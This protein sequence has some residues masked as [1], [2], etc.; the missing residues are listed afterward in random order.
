MIAV[1]TSAARS[2]RFDVRQFR[3]MMAAGV[4]QDQKVELVAGRIYVM[5]DLPPHTFAIGRLIRGLLVMFA[6]DQWTVRQEQPVLLGRFWAPKPDI[7]VLRGDDTN[8]ANRH[9]RR[10]DV[11]V[12]IEVSDTTYFRDRGRKW[13]RYAAA[14]IPTYIIVRLKG[15]DTVVEVWT[16]PT[17]RGMAA[18]YTDVIRY[19]ARANE[20][21][22]IEI[23]GHE[24]GRIAVADLV[25]RPA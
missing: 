12:L 6:V 7:A 19:A 16:G 21:V 23:D 22:P 25:A 2:Y 17:G 8:Y 1:M 11:A 24:Y 10:R 13:R 20:S 15:P 9:P 18:R 3:R 14:G 4:F 5:T